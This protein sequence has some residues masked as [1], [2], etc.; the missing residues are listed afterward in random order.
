MDSRRLLD[1]LVGV[2]VSLV[3]VTASALLQWKVIAPTFSV[4]KAVVIGLAIAA[5]VA[6]VA[7]TVQD[8]EEK[9]SSRSVMAVAAGLP[10]AYLPYVLLVPEP[11]SM[12]ALVAGAGLCATIPGASIVSVA[13]RI[14][15]RRLRE[16]A[17][18]R[19]VV[20]VGAYEG[21]ALRGWLHVGKTQYTIVVVALLLGALA[22]SG[23]ESLVSNPIIMISFF[24]INV[25]S[26]LEKRILKRRG[27]DGSMI[28]VT[29]IGL[30]G[31]RFMK[32]W[33]SRS[34]IQWD[35]FDGYRV[36]D[37]AVEIEFSRWL[38]VTWKFDRE[39]ISDDTA[40]IDGL[41]ENLPRLDDEQ[42]GET[43]KDAR[44]TPVG[45]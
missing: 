18:E 1:A 29:D 10:L 16:A 21:T 20:T 9:L 42:S 25:F 37:N 4:G 24:G 2:Y 3:V 41:S 5:V 17:T 44:S 40:L 35:E 22:V 15:S 11:G 26:F 13:K 34:V 43:V 38:P 31:D 39:E 6:F 33:I 45:E 30:G 14:N 7:G 12:Q 23:P 8:L 32:G 19:A 28:E 27:D 36:T